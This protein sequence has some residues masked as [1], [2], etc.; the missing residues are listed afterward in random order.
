MIVG[1]TRRLVGAAPDDGDS[2]VLVPPPQQDDLAED[3]AGPL[4][5]SWSASQAAA[6]PAAVS[7][8]AS[9]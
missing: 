3:L 6:S 7:V 4:T 5:A 8:N 1:R 9:S 2:F